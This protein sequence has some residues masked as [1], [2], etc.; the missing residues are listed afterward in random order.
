MKAFLCILSV[1]LL[2]S[3]AF[4]VASLEKIDVKILDPSMAKCTIKIN[5][6]PPKT[7]DI[8]SKVLIFLTLTQFLTN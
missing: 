2:A 7:V 3:E 1:S 5:P 4:A 8:D 6:G